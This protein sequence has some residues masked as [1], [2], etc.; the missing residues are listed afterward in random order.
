[1]NKTP[2]Q[3]DAAAR[4]ES[5]APGANATDAAHAANTAH[6]HATDAALR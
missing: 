1:M 5:P 2:D 6:A 4:P 3:N